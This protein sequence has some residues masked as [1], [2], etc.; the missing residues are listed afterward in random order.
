MGMK[1]TAES[2]R[3]FNSL[4]NEMSTFTGA[5]MKKVTLNTTRD[6]TFTLIAVTPSA[7]KGVKNRGFAKQAYVFASRDLGKS[8]RANF[9]GGSNAARANGHVIVEESRDRISYSIVNTTP[10]IEDLDQGSARNVPA[11]INQKAIDFAS[12]KMAKNLDKLGKRQLAKW[13]R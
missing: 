2:Q 10:F 1:V 9:P 12:K 11:N 6:M 7:K 5:E 4:L 8:P 3:N 13:N